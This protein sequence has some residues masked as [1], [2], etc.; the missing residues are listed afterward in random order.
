MSPFHSIVFE[1]RHRRS[2]I[3]ILPQ[4]LNLDSITDPL[5]FHEV[6]LSVEAAPLVSST[7]APFD[8]FT[9]YFRGGSDFMAYT[10]GSFEDW[11]R[12]A[13]VSG[14]PGWSWNA[15]QKYFRRVRPDNFLLS[16]SRII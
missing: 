3:G 4:S 11:D 6:M 10:R 13:K 16:S 9:Q 12:Y 15:M 1:R 5:L 8:S 2:M 14:D 7:M